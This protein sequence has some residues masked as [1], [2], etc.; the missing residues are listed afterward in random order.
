MALRERLFILTTV[1]V[2]KEH[3]EDGVIEGGA[4]DTNHAPKGRLGAYLIWVSLFDKALKLA[5]R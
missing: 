4:G 3:N 2:R 1:I 5:E